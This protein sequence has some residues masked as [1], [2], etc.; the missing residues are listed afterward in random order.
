MKG[1]FGLR[2]YNLGQRREQ[3]TDSSLWPRRPGGPLVW[4]H[5]P[6]ALAAPAMRELARRLT[7]EDGVTVLMTGGPG[8]EAEEDAI[9][10]PTPADTEAVARAFLDHWRPEVAVFADGELLPALIHEAAERS[11]ALLLVDGREP[12]LPRERDG[13]FPGL[14]RRTLSR[15]GHV[16]CIDE[17][18]ARAFRKAG[19]PLSAVA[20]TGRMEARSAALPCLE[21]ERE[22]LARL[23]AARPV[24][25]ACAVPEAEEPAILTAHR[26]VL[27]TTHRLLLIVLPEDPARAA[28]LALR[29]EEEGLTVSQRSLE[30]EPDPETEVYVVETAAELGLWY[31][32][33][34]VTFLGGSLSGEGAVRD[35]LEVAA[36]G[37]AIL[38]GPR[39][40]PHGVSMGR[41]GAARAARAVSSARDLADALGE[42]LAPDRAARLA[43][44]A[45]AVASD[46]AEVTDALHARIRRLMDGEPG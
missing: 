14:M 34:P 37:S 38:H 18:A 40:G 11:I 17:A 4:L 27:A 15:F 22:A 39:P 21:A 9:V 41:L 19:A 43:H 29:F 44:A 28:A 16:A 2:L 45:W 12:R 31:R 6:G 35:P 25:F 33:A 42:L 1:P 8:L 20:V 36:L 46:G 23:L 26:A 13:W 32:L 10:L 3:G 24:W 5:V 30:Q 7:E